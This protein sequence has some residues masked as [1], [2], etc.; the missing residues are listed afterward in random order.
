MIERKTLRHDIKQYLTEAIMSGQLAPGERIVETRLAK[1]LQ[2]SQAPV[3]EAIRELEQMNLIETIPHQGAFVKKFTKCEIVD[4]YVVRE[5]LE[6][7]AAQLA[8][9]RISGDQIAELHK[10]VDNMVELAKIGNRTEFAENDRAFHEKIFEIAGNKLLQKTFS[11]VRLNNL[12]IMNAKMSNRELSELAI[13]HKDVL[14]ALE[15]RDPVKA[16]KIARL[17]IREIAN[18]VL[19]KI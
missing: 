8:T 11:L 16:D 18:E 7:V 2:V 12:F 17:H 4:A 19:T 9:E 10:Y 14:N 5:A 3:R 13:R 1:E 15:E 6:G